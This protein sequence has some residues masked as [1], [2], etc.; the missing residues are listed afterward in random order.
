MAYSLWESSHTDVWAGSY[1][2]AA[3]HFDG[4]AWTYV[5]SGVSGFLTTMWG[6]ATNDVWMGGGNVSGILHWNGT[7]LASVS[8][9]TSISLLWGISANNVYA[10]ASSGS[11]YHWNGTMWAAVTGVSANSFNALWG[12]SS[13]DLW[14][15]GA[16]VWHW[17]GTSWTVALDTATT[18][19]S[20][21]GSGTSDV[22]VTGEGGAWHYN[23]TVWAPVND[24]GTGRIT[25]NLIWGNSASDIWISSGSTNRLVHWNGRNWLRSWP[26]GGISA[27]TGLA[28][29]ADLW[30]ISADKVISRRN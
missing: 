29:T 28:G 18:F 10:Y 20:I 16:S 12:T 25:G 21:W 27:L 23:G 24:D 1:N 6:S 3:Y 9:P 30:T 13:S 19:T 22:W 11:I 5:S 17:N 4:T 26:P 14:G 7:S 8:I 15:V 2:G